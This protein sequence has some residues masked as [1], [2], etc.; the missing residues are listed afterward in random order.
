MKPVPFKAVLDANVL[1]PFTLRDTLLRAASAGLFQICWTAQILEETCRNLVTAGVMS[2]EKSVRLRAVMEKAFP[3]AMVIGYKKLILSMRNQK[4]DRHVAAA[5]VKA[6]AD[7]I[8]TSN[9]KDFREL[10]DGIKARSPDDFLC[11]VFGLD[12][13]GIVE[14]L[15]EQAADLRKPPRSFEDLLNGLEKIVPRFTANIRRSIT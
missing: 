7:I 13:D 9:L 3:E 11:S 5:A 12:P 10:P 8:V 6:G 2:A 15:K 4:K 1:Y 14:L